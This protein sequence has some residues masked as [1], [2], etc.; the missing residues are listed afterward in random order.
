MRRNPETYLRLVPLLGHRPPTRVLQLSLSWAFL[1][2]LLQVSP[3]LLMSTSES[4]LHEFLGRPLFLFPYGFQDRACL[5][6]LVEGFRRV[7]PIHH[8][9]V[10]MI[11]ASAGLWLVL[12]HR[13]SLLML[14]GQRICKILRRHELIK[15][16]P[17]EPV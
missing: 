2:S 15:V 8:Q 5:V 12:C 9:R 1:S 3:S 4:R 10:I 14:I 7:W 11:S 16:Q 13:S 17:R 6:M